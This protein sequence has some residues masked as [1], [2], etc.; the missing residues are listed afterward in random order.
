MTTHRFGKGWWLVAAGMAIGVGWGGPVG[1]GDEAAKGLL[2]AACDGCHRGKFG[3]DATRIFTRPER[4]TTSLKDLQ[5]KVAFCNQ[6]VGAQWF[7]E[8]VKS[9]ADYLNRQFYHF[10]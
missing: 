10:K 3:G 5:E 9:V 4:K 1:A 2:A 7:D 8:D 6:M